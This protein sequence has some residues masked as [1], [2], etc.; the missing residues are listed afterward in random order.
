MSAVGYRQRDRGPGRFGNRVMPQHGVLGAMEKQEDAGRG[1]RTYR[2]TPRV[3]SRAATHA[4]AVAATIATTWP[5][6][7]LDSGASVASSPRAHQVI[8][9]KTHVAPVAKNKTVPKPG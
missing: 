3:G 8:S 1:S 9:P 4:A 7:Q 6:A 5:A 2:P